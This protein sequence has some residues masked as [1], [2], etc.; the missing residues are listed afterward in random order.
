MSHIKPIDPT[1]ELCQYTC[2]TSE[3][4]TAVAA[5]SPTPSGSSDGPVN[6][7]C[8]G[9]YKHEDSEREP[10]KGRLILLSVHDATSQELH[11][12]TT[13]N[14][15][16]CVY[17]LTIVGSFIVAAVNSAVCG[18]ILSLLGHCLIIPILGSV[19]PTRIG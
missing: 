16:G 15:D 6:L 2:E 13:R 9:T 3:C 12:V 7:F 1:V 17:A 8:L 5:M 14:V 10:T 11:V 19:V 4:I 18:R